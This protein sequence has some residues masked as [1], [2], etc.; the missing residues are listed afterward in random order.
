MGESVFYM[1]TEE[2]FANVE[3]YLVKQNKLTTK[4]LNIMELED[5][6]IIEWERMYIYGLNVITDEIGQL[7]STEL[8]LKIPSE[9]S[10]GYVV[11]YMKPLCKDYRLTVIKL[12]Y[13]VNSSVN[14]KV[15]HDYTMKLIPTALLEFLKHKGLIN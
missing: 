4:S 6:K 15:E 13:D 14:K 11:E 8:N 10:Y 7:Y 5:E 12:S 9:H 2:E 3:G 1:L